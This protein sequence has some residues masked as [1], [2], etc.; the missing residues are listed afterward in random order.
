MTLN[1]VVVVFLFLL[2]FVMTLFVN[3]SFASLLFEDDFDSGMS[4]EWVSIRPLQ[5]VEDGWLHSQDSYLYWGRD[6]SAFVHDG[7]MSW[8]DYTLS[9]KVDPLQTGSWE[10]ATVFFRTSDIVA[11]TYGVTGNYYRLEIIGPGDTDGQRISLSRKTNS[12]SSEV[13]FNEQCS[14]SSDPMV[15]EIAVTVGTIQVCLNGAEIINLVDTNPL[16]YGGIGVGA[17][18]EAEAKFDDIVVN[19]ISCY[20]CVGFEPPMDKI[21]KVKK[22][23]RVLPLKMLLLDENNME[24][25]DLDIETAPL[26]EVDFTGGD[27]TEP[28][29]EDFLAAGQGD[30]GN[31][32]VYTDEGKWQ[33][34]LQTKNFSGP[35]LYTIRAVS[36]NPNTYIIDSTCTAQFVID[37]N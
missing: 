9:L 15:F 34:N 31:M 14:T 5:W 23:N 28:P 22:P 25:S 21:V 10:R 4:S 19:S 24:I 12:G 27:P 35:G 7:D 11:T 26:V 18:W 33:F 29:E 36:G 13:L 6:S 1:K 8:T 16:L 30:E 17:I 3:N 37:S 20:T 32:F 2:S